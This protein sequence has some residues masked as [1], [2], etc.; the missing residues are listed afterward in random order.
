MISTSLAG[1]EFNKKKG[2][3]SPSYFIYSHFKER[4]LELTRST[5]PCGGGDLRRL[6]PT[7]PPSALTTPVIFDPVQLFHK[8]TKIP[9]SSLSTYNTQH[10]QPFPLRPTLASVFPRPGKALGSSQ[11]LLFLSR[12]LSHG[13][14]KVVELN[15][16]VDILTSCSPTKTHSTNSKA[17]QLGLLSG[18]AGI[19]PRTPSS[20]ELKS[21]IDW[22]TPLSGSV[23]TLQTQLQHLCGDSGGRWRYFTNMFLSTSV[24]K[25]F[26][27]QN[28]SGEYWKTFQGQLQHR[29]DTVVTFMFNIDLSSP[30]IYQLKV[31]IN[32]FLQY[33][34]TP[35]CRARLSRTPRYLEQNRISLG[36]A[37]VSFSHLYGLSRTP[38]YLELFLASLSSN[39][40]RLS[41]LYYVPKKH[42]STS[43]RKCS[44]GTSWQDRTESWQMYWCVHGITNAKSDWLDSPLNAEGDKLPV[45]RDQTI[46]PEIWRTSLSRTPA[47]SNN[48]IPLRVRDS[49]VLLYTWWSK[50]VTKA[51]VRRYV[52]W[53]VKVYL[54]W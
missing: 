30:G 23:A 17:Y 7:P 35:L 33:S 53:A 8:H 39:Q 29:N 20:V 18:L 11:A 9:I 28:T 6:I 36:F 26:Q 3:C 5:M 48:S 38:R 13:S 43:V 4:G 32:E 22:A 45:F 37:L 40:P 31:H 42:W 51:L 14:G 52:I 19:S 21:D 25:L 46:A 15:G 24:S 27:F 47:I 34:W 12:F 41:R 54:I 44:Q 10:T 16:F 49:G 50:E 2:G 1:H